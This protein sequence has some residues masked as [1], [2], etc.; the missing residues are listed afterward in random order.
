MKGR[1]KLGNGRSCSEGRLVKP[2]RGKDAMLY[3]VCLETMQP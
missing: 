2:A 3:F 1:L